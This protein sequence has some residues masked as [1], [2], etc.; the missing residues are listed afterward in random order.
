MTAPNATG[1]KPVRYELFTKGIELFTH[2]DP[3]RIEFGLMVVSI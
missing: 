2:I 3:M 1:R